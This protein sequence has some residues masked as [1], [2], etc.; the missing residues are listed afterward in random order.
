MF[1]LSYYTFYVT[2]IYDISTYIYDICRDL[3]YVTTPT[4]IRTP[5]YTCVIA[6]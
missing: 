6:V 4:P 3:C 2:Y 1:T 5:V